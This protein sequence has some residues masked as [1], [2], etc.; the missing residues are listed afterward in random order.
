MSRLKLNFK[1][2][3]MSRFEFVKKCA[4]TKSDIVI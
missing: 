2:Y 4:V 3:I 1:G